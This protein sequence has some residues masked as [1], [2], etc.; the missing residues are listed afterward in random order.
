[1]LQGL[2]AAGMDVARLNLSHGTRSDHERRL[3]AVGR[4][5]R[6]AGRLVAVMID[7]RGPEIRTGD[8]AAAVVLETG[9]RVALTAADAPVDTVVDTLQ[10]TPAGEGAVGSARRIGVSYAGLAGDVKAA[11]P[12]ILDD[13]A[14]FL[15]V[16]AADP[17]RGVVLCRVVHGGTLGSRR[18]VTL[19]GVDVD[20]EA[21]TPD[22]REDVA[23]ACGR[24]VDFVAQSFVRRAGD[25]LVLRQILEDCGSSAQI[26][27]KIETRSGYDNLEEIL[28]VADALMVARGDL[29]VELAPEEV[30][31][32]QKRMISRCNRLGRPVITATQMLESMIE[33]PRPTR[34]EASDVANAILDGTDAV[35]LSG[36]TAAGRHPVEAVRQIVRIASRAEDGLDYDAVLERMRALSGRSITDAIGY[37]TS[38]VAHGLKA[39]AILTPTQSGHTARVVAR[40][41]PRARIVAVTPVAAVAAQLQ[42][43]WGVRP[44]VG[45]A[46]G[47]DEETVEAAVKASLEA[48]EVSEGDL[49]VIT[50][51][52]PAGVPGT[53]NMLKVHIV[54]DVLVRGT[55]IGRRPVTAR[56]RV[57]DHHREAEDLRKG[58]VLV[59]RATDRDMMPAIGRAAG[60]VVEEG[61]LTSHAAV[62][63]LSLGIPVIVGA[64]GATGVLQ[65]GQLVTIDPTRGLVYAGEARVL[66]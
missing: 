29:G 23:W 16:E 2:I 52:V 24:D 48:G 54:G 34:A 30:P 1:V 26:V 12:L 22:D 60:M 56:V 59:A 58:E 19:P 39:S 36:E 37:A 66:P 7:T 27:A 44:L 42:L 13:G 49:I 64:G 62:V 53:T 51:G 18:K 38:S 55:G 32:A 43:V 41:R 40:C 20:L 8:L 33:R 15:E 4:A 25:V 65:D 21:L 31:L 5:A 9:G 45:A 63:G 3:E 47:G 50:A 61:G 46:A 57:V 28:Q 14:I 11:D 17:E 35:M 10:G 6:E